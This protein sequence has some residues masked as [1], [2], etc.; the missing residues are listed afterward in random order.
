MLDVSIR[1]K[2]GEFTLDIRFSTS[3]NGV[4]ALFG[5]SGAGKYL[6]HA[7]FV[8][9]F[10]RIRNTLRYFRHSFYHLGGF[11]ALTMRRSCRDK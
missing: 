8:Y 2:Q 3:E 10:F 7:P 5:N 9:F 1:K 6:F 4:T 11:P